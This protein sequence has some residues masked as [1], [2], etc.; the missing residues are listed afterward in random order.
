M[1][2]AVSSIA[3]MCALSSPVFAQEVSN[4]GQP[5]G[6]ILVT[7]ERTPRSIV[8]T[9]SSVAV[10]TQEDL[11]RFAGADTLAR[12][13]EQT[14]NVSPT[15]DDNEG[16]SIRGV[17]SGG[18]LTSLE[19]FFG[20][21]QPRTTV[22]VDGRQLS[23]NEFLFADASAWDIER[24]EVFR[25]PQTTTQ[26]RN[27]IAGAIFVETADPNHGEF[28]SRARAIVGGRD[29]RQLSAMVSGPIGS[30]DLAYR[31]SGDYR[32]EESFV[33]PV[34][35]ADYGV[36]LRQIESLNLRGKLGYEPASLP[37]FNALLTLNHT[38]TQRPQ[39]ESVDTPFFDRERNNSGFSVFATNGE[40]GILDLSYDTGRGAVISNVTTLSRSDVRRLAPTGTGN[41]EI[42]ADD[43][44]NEFM[45]R[46]GDAQSPVSALF[47]SYFSQTDGKDSL[48][49]SGFGLS[50]GDFREER[51]SFGVFGE[52]TVSPFDRFHL[53]GGLRYQWDAQD[54]DGGFAGVIPVDFDQSFDAVLP[55]AELA[56][57]LTDDVRIGVMAEKGFN[58][59]GFTFNFNTFATETF[60]PEYV[61]NYEAFAKARVAGG[62]LLLTGNVFYCDFDDYQVA[63]LTELGPGFFANTFSNAAE[64]R[65]FGAEFGAR[66]EASDA[67][68][69]DFGLG[70]LDT[71]FG[72]DS[73]SGAILDGNEFERAPT[74]TAT[75]GI[76]WQP[77]PG[78]EL[79]G[80]ARYSDGYAS[81]AANVAANIV[82]DYVV[83]DVQASY[84]IGPVRVFAYA[85]NVFG[86]DYEL[87]IFSD[88]NLANI[89]D[90]RRVSAGVE[91]AF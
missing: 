80:F 47:G 35:V 37:G 75:G 41:A 7:G 14:A 90:P 9:S 83:A 17:D 67:L 10:T 40:A 6:E 42:R 32:E 84:A 57:D 26:G 55:R 61:W 5:V 81:D 85:T 23:F 77:L 87:S 31:L 50:V 18:I 73:S 2:F 58:P 64:A 60:A 8:E 33:M 65:A 3:L 44:S 36:D 39:T 69:L 12:I 22:Q 38:D 48:D 4:E 52:L 29:E 53:T 70:L 1:K 45:A 68:F 43:F 76:A 66:Y 72:S 21:S 19:A 78:L 25:G 11:D 30:G 27:A 82:E 62:R 71:R 54:R 79:S 91:F 51:E 46:F 24:V 13:L 74:V 34:G 15:G 28:E 56:Y 59:G 88:G 20:G 89:S 49:L 63:S 16:P 86:N